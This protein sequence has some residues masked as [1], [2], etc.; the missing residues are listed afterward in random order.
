MKKTILI[1]SMILSPTILHAACAKAPDMGNNFY[2]C[3]N[4]E[5][6]CYFFSE[7]QPSPFQISCFRNDKK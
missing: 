5:A 3:E 1:L 7:G 4:S 2:R 6:I